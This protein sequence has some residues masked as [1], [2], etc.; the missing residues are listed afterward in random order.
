MSEIR[1]TQENILARYKGA[2]LIE[3]GSKPY[4]MGSLP[5][6]VKGMPK[7]AQEIWLAAFNSAL[8]QYGDE[9]RA[10]AVAQAAVERDYE[11]VDGRWRKKE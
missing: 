9:G 10:F 2:S 1:Q 8:E 7:H 6:R 5:D 11:L 4:T 3:A